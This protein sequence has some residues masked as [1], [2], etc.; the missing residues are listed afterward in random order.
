MTQTELFLYFTSS[1]IRFPDGS[2]Q[3]TGYLENIQANGFRAKDT[4]VAVLTT[5]DGKSQIANPGYFKE[6][7]DD[8]LEDFVVILKRYRHHSTRT[9]KQSLGEHRETGVGVPALI[10]ID[11]K[12]PMKRGTDYE[13]HYIF[14]QAVPADKIL[15]TLDI[16]DVN[17][18]DL[19]SVCGLVDQYLSIIMNESTG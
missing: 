9:N 4:N 1:A 18:N 2:Q 17:P 12:I 3:S 7:P 15:G 14:D 16:D 10:V 8:L 5:R 11:G 6:H 19:N 13:D